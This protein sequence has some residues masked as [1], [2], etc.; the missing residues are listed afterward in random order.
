MIVYGLDIAATTVSVCRMDTYSAALPKVRLFRAPAAPDVHSVKTADARIR[1]L[2]GDVVTALTRDG[3]PDLVVIVRHTWRTM[4][5]DPSAYR[6]AAVHRDVVRGLLDSGVRVADVPLLTLMSW[7][8]VQPKMG[9]PY[10]AALERDTKKRHPGMSE[11][12]GFS[13]T[14]VVAAGIG[15]QA[16]GQPSG[17]SFTGRRHDV[18]TSRA[19]GVGVEK[20]VGP[21]W[22][23]G[24][25]VAPT[26]V[27]QT[28]P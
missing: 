16:L 1:A 25:P 8:G 4:H 26:K 13:T 9:A 18:M 2:A 11:P 19:S 7:A 15:A 10:L 12:E 6:R 22:P 20:Q 24:L 3:S 5:A 14:A 28:Q 21:Q 17:W 23:K 27:G